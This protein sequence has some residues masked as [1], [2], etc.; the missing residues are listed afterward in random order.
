MVGE[1]AQIVLSSQKIAPR[2]AVETGYQFK[3]DNVEDALRAA[4][5]R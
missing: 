4:L 2:V 5:G 1:F 3:H